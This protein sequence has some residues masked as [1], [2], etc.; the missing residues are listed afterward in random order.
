M[1]LRAASALPLEQEAH[2]EALSYLKE[3]V[4]RYQNWEGA[5]VVINA[6]DVTERILESSTTGESLTI[7]I[8]TAFSRALDVKEPTDTANSIRVKI[9]KE[10]PTF[11]LWL[12]GIGHVTIEETEQVE[13][14]PYTMMTIV[15]DI[16]GATKFGTL[17]GRREEGRSF[18]RSSWIQCNEEDPSNIYITVDDAIRASLD[19]TTSKDLTDIITRMKMSIAL[20]NSASGEYERSRA[21]H[22]M[23][24]ITDRSPT[25]VPDDELQGQECWRENLWIGTESEDEEY[26]K[27]A[28][29]AMHYAK[30]AAENNIFIAIVSAGSLIDRN[31]MQEMTALGQHCWIPT[32]D[33]LKGFSYEYFLYGGPRFVE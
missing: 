11:F 19:D 7:W 13:T 23:L 21:T 33:E 1:V 5:K 20:L 32:L 4:Y 14:M 10:V 18:A 6:G 31:L 16:A 25:T 17:C 15:S 22:V 30:L 27:A 24:I 2:E 8:D 26:Q 29:C 12:F 28:D 9:R 3:E